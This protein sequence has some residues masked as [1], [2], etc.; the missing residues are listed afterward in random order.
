MK[1]IINLNLLKIVYVR[2]SEIKAPFLFYEVGTQ[3]FIINGALG[4]S[5]CK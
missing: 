4:K 3:F 2:L 5:L 1:K